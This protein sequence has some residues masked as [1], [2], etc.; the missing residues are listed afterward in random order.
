MILEMDGVIV[1][2]YLGKKI[3][4]WFVSL[5]RKEMLFFYNIF[6][7]VKFE[8]DYIDFFNGEVV[9]LVIVI[10]DVVIFLRLQDRKVKISEIIK[11]ILVM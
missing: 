8:E 5:I 2:G 10:V 4:L 3:L 11:Y 1:Y 7:G 9:M 6:C